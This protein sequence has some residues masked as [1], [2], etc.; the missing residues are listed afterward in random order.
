MYRYAHNNSAIGGKLTHV[1]FWHTAHYLGKRQRCSIAKIMKTHYARDPETGYLGLYV[2]I[3][4]KT[5]GSE[6]HYF[7]R[8]KPPARLGLAASP[9]YRV[10][11][12]Q[13]YL[14][15]DWAK[16]R[17]QHKRLETRTRAGRRC[18]HCGIS[19]VMLYVHHPNRLANKRRDKKGRANV[20]QSGVEQKTILLCQKCHLSYHHAK[21]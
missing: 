1:I 7:V 21:S 8:N 19:G 14:N 18:E 6:N 11:D 10:Q 17:S 15:I 2:P 13:P 12:K 3:P 9:A 4:G 16:G 20:A 5:R